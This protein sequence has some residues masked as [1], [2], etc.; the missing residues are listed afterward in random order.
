MHTLPYHLHR[1]GQYHAD[2]AVSHEFG[3]GLLDEILDIVH[4]VDATLLQQLTDLR[5]ALIFFLGA[6]LS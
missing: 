6:I 4:T 3:N 1:S 2:F 5:S